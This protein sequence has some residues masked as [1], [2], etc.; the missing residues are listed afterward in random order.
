MHTPEEIGID[1]FQA[2]RSPDERYRTAPLQGLWTHQKGGFYHDGRF[3]TLGAVVTH[4]NRDFSLGLSTPE[5]HDPRR[6][7]QVAL[8]RWPCVSQPAPAIVSRIFAS[9]ACWA[10]LRSF[11]ACRLS[12]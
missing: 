10:P 7:P 4:Y 1:D 5:Q 6:V 8:D 9:A 12:G 3:A 2:D 11:F